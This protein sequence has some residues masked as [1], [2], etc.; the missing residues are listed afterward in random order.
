MEALFDKNRRTLIPGPSVPDEVEVR[1]I[2]SELC[3]AGADI[4]EGN[5]IYII[6]DRMIR[7]KKKFSALYKIKRLTFPKQATFQMYGV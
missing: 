3:F 5:C 4:L 7:R 6:Y 2:I 1:D